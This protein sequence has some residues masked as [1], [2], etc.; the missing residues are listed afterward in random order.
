M[1]NVHFDST[2]TKDQFHERV[3]ADFTT[4]AARYDDEVTGCMGPSMRDEITEHLLALYPP[5]SPV[6]DVAC[7]T[8]RLC[9]SALRA[10]CAEVTG[11]DITPAMLAHGR[12]NFPG[13]S[14]VEGRAE[15]LPFADEAFAS[16]YVSSALVYFVD[17][18]Q[19]LRE[20]RRVLKPGGFLAFQCTSG[21]SYVIGVAMQD[22][23]AQVLGEDA[24][25]KIFVVPG[26]V[27]DTP[28]V[29]RALLN[30]AGF[31]EPKVA[32]MEK[33]PVLDVN[34]VLGT[35]RGG[36]FNNAFLTRLDRL[37]DDVKAEIRKKFLVEIEKYR[38]KEDGVLRDTIRHWFVQCR[39]PSS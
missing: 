8:G 25:K 22:A 27:T 37:D 28:D 26:T 7:G 9:G 15:Q 20:M 29:L 4:R 23:C 13:A 39:K 5:R 16:V 38:S 33:T 6:L 11:L 10:G 21:D 24:A 17:V 32:A 19:A 31:E 2:F 12:R 35:W 14:F 18:P 3:R 1:A 34:T 36:L 30:T